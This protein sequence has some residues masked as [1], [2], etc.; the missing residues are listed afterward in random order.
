MRRARR[1]PRARPSASLL[2]ARREELARLAVGADEWATLSQAQTRL[3]HAASLL[4]TASAAEDA[5]TEGDDA[6]AARLGTIVSRLQAGVAHDPALADIVAL[7]EPASIQLREA[8]RE[9]RMY[10]Q[11]LDLDPGELARVEERLGAIHDMARKHRVRPEAL[12]EL[13][14]DTEARIALLA[15][16]ADFDLLERKAAQAQASYRAFAEQLSAKRRE[17]AVELGHRVTSAMQELAM[18]GGRLEI[19]LVPCDPPSSHGLES[20]EFRVASH[21][22]AAAR[23]AR[24]RGVGRRALAHCARHPGGDERSGRRADARLR[25]SGRG[26]RRHRRGYRGSTH[27]GARR[28]TPGAVRHPSAAGGRRLPTRT[29]R[30]S[31]TATRRACAPR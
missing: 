14:A 3:A 22:E 15:A 25:R 1:R 9:L 16:A 6:I 23:A 2:H 4:E 21:P 8:S 18:A 10:R 26:H 13:L 31:S 12:P 29:S 20:I 5:L 30:W 7:L 24:A 17:A 27:A 28:A 11:R 19:A